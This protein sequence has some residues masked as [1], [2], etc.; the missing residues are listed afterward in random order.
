M[1]AVPVVISFITI[2]EN[3]NCVLMWIVISI[4]SLKTGMVEGFPHKYYAES[5]WAKSDL[6]ALKE[7]FCLYH[8][9]DAK[10]QVS[11]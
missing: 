2:K 7:M 6:E 11:I 9:E 5:D 8:D 10:V 4:T 3:K 1:A